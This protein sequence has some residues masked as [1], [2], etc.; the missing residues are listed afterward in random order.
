MAAPPFAGR[1]P[2]A[3]GDDHTDED[4]FAAAKRLGG[5]GVL[6]G[7]PRESAA[8]YTLAGPAAV[9]AWLKSG[10]QS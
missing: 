3:I 4:A 2:I 8:A 5:N 7:E 6:V 9:I 1:I 10:L